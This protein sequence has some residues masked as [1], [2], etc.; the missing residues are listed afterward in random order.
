MSSY[1]CSAC[2]GKCCR[3]NDFGYRVYHM[4]AESY[5]HWCEHCH[6]GSVPP[7]DPR[8]EEIAQLRRVLRQ[9]LDEYPYL[10]CVCGRVK[11]RIKDDVRV[12]ARK[13]LEGKP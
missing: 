11:D 6:D 12:E 8:D 7:P 5:E 2:K 9:I 13:L 3:D 1:D 4:G 10:H